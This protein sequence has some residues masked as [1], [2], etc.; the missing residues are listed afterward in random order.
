MP[1]RPRTSTTALRASPTRQT[2][3]PYRWH[4]ACRRSPPSQATR[5]LPCSTSPSRSSPP[6]ADSAPT[7]T[8]AC[9][10]LNDV[11]P[12]IAVDLAVQVDG[13]GPS[14]YE[15]PENADSKLNIYGEDG[16][17]C[18]LLGWVDE[19]VKGAGH[20]DVDDHH[21]TLQH[22]YNAMKQVDSDAGCNEDRGP[23]V[24]GPSEPWSLSPGS[25]FE[26]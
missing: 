23:E 21:V 6:S 24:E 17:S 9:G 4:G 7:T 2:P 20:T 15:V 25:D 11:D 22:I 3:S 10:H 16:W 13:V 14:T 5:R 18:A 12:P 19:K 8:L 1:G 26:F